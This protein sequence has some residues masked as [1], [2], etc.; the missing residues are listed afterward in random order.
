MLPLRSRAAAVHIWRAS[1]M[2]ANRGQLVAMA[3]PDVDRGVGA[4]G[5]GGCAVD[6]DGGPK[7]DPK[8]ERC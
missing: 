3:S 6:R 1:A 2:G 8:V 4:R 5:A 7:K